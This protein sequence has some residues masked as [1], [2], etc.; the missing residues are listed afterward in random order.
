MPCWGWLQP[1]EF[2]SLITDK[3]AALR[4]D[5]DLKEVVI[6]ETT[7]AKQAS[8]PGFSGA[9]KAAVRLLGEDT[10]D[11]F[12]A[13]VDVGRARMQ[14]IRP[15]SFIALSLIRVA[16]KRKALKLYSGATFV[17]WGTR[18]GEGGGPVAG[19][20]GAGQRQVAQC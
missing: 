16:G 18:A 1:V 7:L 4:R 8:P 13:A 6:F 19:S 3:A 20:G 2:A 15:L 10:A 9:V 17:R 12:A 14:K 5:I 11:P